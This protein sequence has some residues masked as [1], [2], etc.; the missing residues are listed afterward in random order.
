MRVFVTGGTG[1]IGSRLINRLVA[2]KDEVYLLTRKPSPRPEFFGDQV[3]TIAGD[4]TQSGPWQAKA[5]DCDAVV[6]LAGENLFARRWNE[7]F[8]K[9]LV[10]SRVQSTNNVVRALSLSPR[11]SNGTVKVL[12]NGSAIGIYGPHGD[13]EL[14]ENSR[15]GSDFLA[16]LCVDWEKAAKQAESAGVRCTIIRIGIVLDKKGGALAK[17][18]TPFKLGAGG[19]I[20]D[21][22]QYMS[23]IHLDDLCSLILACLDRTDISGPLNGTA[24][25]PVTNRE[26]AKAMGRAIH[27]PAFMP[28]PRFALRALLGE[29]ADV[30]A[31]GQ[32]V[33]PGRAMEMGFRFEYPTV[34]AA[35]AQIFA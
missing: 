35:L 5:G 26:F 14:T 23:W 29:S 2:R 20:G 31:T 19:P 12:V 32:R 25:N 13:E 33:L 6:N 18:L 17:M 30:V 7:V 11:R 22:K 1:L 8:K 16:G 27:R 15:A 4:P 34:D 3:Q 9:T 21:G 24:P 28:T 10:D